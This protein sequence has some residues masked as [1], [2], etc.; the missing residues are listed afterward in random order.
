MGIHDE[1]IDLISVT[2]N[3]ADDFSPP[4]Q[5][6][7]ILNLVCNL[8][9]R[10]QK[11]IRLNT[12]RLSHFVKALVVYSHIFLKELFFEGNADNI[13]YRDTIIGIFHFIY[14]YFHS[15]MIQSFF[16]SL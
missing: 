11:V 16:A 3:G 2:R 5:E 4:G 14:N 12:Q 15:I 6:I 8:L 9:I 7:D 1:I 13:T 10:I